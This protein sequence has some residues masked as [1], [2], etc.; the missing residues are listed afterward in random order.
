MIKT[1]LSTGALLSVEGE[2]LITVLDTVVLHVFILCFSGFGGRERERAI[3]P[4]SLACFTGVTC[5]CNVDSCKSRIMFV[6]C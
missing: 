2:S 5:Y 4:P 3:V 1:S 6:N